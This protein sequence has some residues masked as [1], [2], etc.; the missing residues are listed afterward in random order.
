M[1][2]MEFD[3]KN[4]QAERAVIAFAQK[5]A[6]RTKFIDIMSDKTGKVIGLIKYLSNDGN[7]PSSKP[8]TDKHSLSVSDFYMA[9]SIMLMVKIQLTNAISFE[10]VPL[11]VFLQMNE[12]NRNIDMG[13]MSFA[14]KYRI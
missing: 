2:K 10:I 12:L 6:G 14:N 5:Y 1:T 9:K 8:F 13:Q 7:K 11:N 4:L 3:E